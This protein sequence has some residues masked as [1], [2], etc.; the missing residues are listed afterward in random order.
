MNQTKQS[1]DD[2]QKYIRPN[3]CPYNP[4]IAAATPFI[5]E[6]ERF[7]VQQYRLG[8]SFDAI[9]DDVNLASSNYVKT[10]FLEAL[11]KAKLFKDADAETKPRDNICHFLE[12]LGIFRET[13]GAEELTIA[14]ELAMED[15][16]R[17]KNMS[18]MLYPLVA[19][20]LY[21]RPVT[22]MSRILNLLRNIRSHPSASA[23]FSRILMEN[24]QINV[25]FFIEGVIRY[26]Q[27]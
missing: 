26:L 22:V 6:L 12:S 8:R 10:L 2:L 4:K 11:D 7:I 13:A 16:T 14:I 20:Q 27:G 23:F 5:S 9:A 3:D 24:S 21:E 19:A 15:R 17:L 1:I 18:K 25:R